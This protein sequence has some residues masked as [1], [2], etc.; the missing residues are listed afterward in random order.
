M[1]GW[2]LDSRIA[3]RECDD[4]SGHFP[5]VWPIVRSG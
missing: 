1:A 4:F 3:P 2:V 5:V